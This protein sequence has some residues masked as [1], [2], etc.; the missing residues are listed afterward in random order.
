MTNHLHISKFDTERLEFGH[1]DGRNVFDTAPGRDF[2]FS[3]RLQW[4]ATDRNRCFRR[5][6]RVGGACVDCQ[7]QG[8][9]HATADERSMT[10]DETFRGI[11]F[12][13]SHPLKSGRVSSRERIL[14]VLDQNFLLFGTLG[15]D[16]VDFFSTR[17]MGDEPSR[18]GR[19][20]R[21]VRFIDGNKQ[22]FSMKS[23]SNLSNS[24]IFYHG[25]RIP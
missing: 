14:G 5:Y 12:E 3:T 4:I 16:L 18:H 11:K 7:F 25:R 17:T 20:R 19:R 13:T 15:E 6:H 22:P 21:F 23:F 8:K 1:E 9:F 24:L 10:D 2:D